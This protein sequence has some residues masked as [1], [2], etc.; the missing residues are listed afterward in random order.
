MRRMFRQLQ[1]ETIL[2]VLPALFTASLT[3]YILAGRYPN[4]V[5][6][7]LPCLLIF[8]LAALVGIFHR[9]H[10]SL[11]AWLLVAGCVAVV[12]LLVF[13]MH[14]TIGII[15]LAIP[16]GLAALF[17]SFLGGIA[18]ATIC[19]V[20]VLW[21]SSLLPAMPGLTSITVVIIWSVLGLIL[22]TL[23]P[24]LT[25]LRWSWSSSEQNR[26]LVEQA[27]DQRLHLK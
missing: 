26:R 27:R 11:S 12:W 9:R 7:L 1:E 10:Y 17:V 4:P 15:L 19:T 23:W 13:R 3:F 20:L 21:L 24:L 6:A 22:L 14:L 18:V 16:T 25:A 8:F 5:D 2:W